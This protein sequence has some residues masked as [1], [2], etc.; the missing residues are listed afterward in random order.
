[1]TVRAF[2]KTGHFLA[3]RADLWFNRK[4]EANE[5]PVGALEKMERA[6]NLP[7]DST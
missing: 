5:E 4:G 6:K 7:S 3:K 1:M 2:L